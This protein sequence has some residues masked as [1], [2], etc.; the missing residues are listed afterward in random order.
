MIWLS[1]LQALK[2][3]KTLIGGLQTN[4]DVTTQLTSMGEGSQVGQHPHADELSSSNLRTKQ[5]YRTPRNVE[6]TPA[7]H[8]NLDERTAALEE[9]T[10]SEKLL[11]ETATPRSAGQLFS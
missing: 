10:T 1:P 3:W 6:R 2:F 8:M 4:R 7:L 5:A 11:R 9:D